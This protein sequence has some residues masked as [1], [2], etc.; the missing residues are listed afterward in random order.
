MN[1]KIGGKILKVVY[2]DDLRAE[3]GKRVNGTLHAEKRQISV[4]TDIDPI[5]QKEVI[6][7]ESLHAIVEYFNVG[8]DE[9]VTVRIANGIKAWIIDNPEFIKGIIKDD[10]KERRKSS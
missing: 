1:I 2:D 4:A 5:M 10:E 6:I 3:D 8:D 7:H 9:S